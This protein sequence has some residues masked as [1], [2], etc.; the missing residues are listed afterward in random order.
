LVI[1]RGVVSAPEYRNVPD[2]DAS[3]TAMWEIVT[4]PPS[5]AVHDGNVVVAAFDPADAADHVICFRDAPTVPVHVDVVPAAPGSAVCSSI[6]AAAG[7]VNA[8][9]PSMSSHLFARFVVASPV[10]TVPPHDPRRPGL[11]RCQGRGRG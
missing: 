5:H 8:D 6:H 4:D 9:A 7:A 1:A 2:V 11:V 3:H 10:V